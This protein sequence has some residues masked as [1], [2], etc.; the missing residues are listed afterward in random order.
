MTTERSSHDTLTIDEVAEM[1][2][3]SRRTVERWISH[4]DLP[5]QKLPGGLVRITRE[6]AEAL[7]APVAPSP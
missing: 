5:A 1:H 2:R 3:V 4:G 6:A 7:L